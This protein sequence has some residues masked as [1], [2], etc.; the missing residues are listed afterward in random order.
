MK[1][2][3]IVLIIGILT[4]VPF[5]ICYIVDPV[6][7]SSVTSLSRSNLLYI[8]LF[9]SIFFIVAAFIGTFLSK[10][11]PSNGNI[12]PNISIS[13][14]TT[15]I[16][17]LAICSG[18]AAI[19]SALSTSLSLS[20]LF[21]LTFL[22]VFSILAGITFIVTSICF[23]SGKNIF[24]K[25]PLLCLIPS[26]WFIIRISLFLIQHVVTPINVLYICVIFEYIF[27][28]LFVFNNAKQ[29]IF[30][31]DKGVV[32]NI[33]MFGIPA[34]LFSLMYN[35]SIIYFK[36]SG[37][38][39]YTTGYSI[40]C[41]I[42]LLISLYILLDM[43]YILKNEKYNRVIPEIDEER[44]KELDRLVEEVYSKLDDDFMNNI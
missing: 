19:V 20:T 38:P 33:F 5:E 1:Y 28:L 14:V 29:F 36:F 26:I 7:V 40:D 16:G 31:Q 42:D 11:V 2:T 44:D 30:L 6:F 18:G 10:N 35:L 43:I 13:L 3:I 12:L 22:S 39:D 27:M 32:K 9:T 4:L 23:F 8:S 21:K 37:V 34:I 41:I 15:S 25:V 17:L 24:K